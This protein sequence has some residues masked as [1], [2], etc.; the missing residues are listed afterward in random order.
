MNI[1]AVPV[2][3]SLQRKRVVPRAHH[4]DI[5][6]LVSLPG[7]SRE[8]ISGSKDA[9]IKIWS[10]TGAECRRVIGGICHIFIHD[11][12]TSET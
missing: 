7:Q 12:P 8:F 6:G 11:T 9:F 5:H 2:M 3:V 4:D 1:F 10:Q